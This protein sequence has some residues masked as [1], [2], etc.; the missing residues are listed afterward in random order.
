MPP[1]DSP[2]DLVPIIASALAHSRSV[3]GGRDADGHAV[4]QVQ[5][6]QFRSLDEEALVQAQLEERRR[7]QETDRWI[8]RAIGA[9][10]GLLCGGLS[11]GFDLG[12]L[13]TAFV[14][15]AMGGLTVDG[16]NHLSDREL[17]DL[18]LEWTTHAESFLYH[19][20]RHGPA[21]QR[22][23]MLLPMAEGEP[24]RTGHGVRFQDGYIGFFDP[25]P[26]ASD[27]PLLC[28]A[29]QLNGS[30][31][32]PDL[33]HPAQVIAAWPCSDGRERPL[34]LLPTDQGTWLALAVPVPHH[35]LY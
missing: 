1:V 28:G 23:L 35:S 25:T 21:R 12:D 7:Q 30:G 2:Q 29:R 15:G 22:V 31:L 24:W 20:R 19:R 33:E 26:I 6:L 17:A 8:G 10:L 16:L 9:G 34:E 4:V 32:S 18:G 5:R 11:D 13:T 3:D 27:A 14:G